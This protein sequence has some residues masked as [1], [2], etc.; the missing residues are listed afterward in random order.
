MEETACDAAAAP[1]AP[2][3]PI[4][5]ARKKELLALGEKIAATATENVPVG[6]ERCF[7]RSAV[8]LFL[9]RDY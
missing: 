8:M 9:D 1:E 7:L 4:S 3:A 2:E 6:R 5:L